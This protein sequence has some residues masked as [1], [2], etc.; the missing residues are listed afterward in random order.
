MDSKPGLT[1]VKDSPWGTAVSVRGIGKQNLVYLIDGSRIETSTN[2]SGGLSLFNMYDIQNIEVVKGGLS[3][4][5]GTGATGGVINI[6]SKQISNS[7]NF[8]FNGEVTSEY[9]N[10]NNKLGNN[11]LLRAGDKY[12]SVKL[13]GSFRNANDTQTPSGKLANSSFHDKS[14]SLLA[15]VYPMK[16]LSL[17]IN[18][19]NFKAWDVGIPGGAPFP[20]KAFAKYLNASRELLSGIINIKNLFKGNTNTSIKFYRQTINRDV[21]LKPNAKVIVQPGAEHTTLGFLLKTEWVLNNNNYLIAGTDIWQRAYDGYRTKKIIPLNKIIADKP[22]PDSKAK[23]IGLFIQD[24]IHLLKKK[25]KL[26]LG[27]RYDFINRNK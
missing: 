10:V 26:T 16:N 7:D 25:I 9:A 3:S 12:W 11:L 24:E 6:I 1:V 27:G 17:K 14:L 19:Q 13:S 20:K 22:L 5:Y 2:H 4:L 8:F 21:E 18:Y 23:N 15:A